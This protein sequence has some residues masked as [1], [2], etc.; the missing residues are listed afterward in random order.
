MET[1]VQEVHILKVKLEKMNVKQ[2]ELERKLKTIEDLAAQTKIKVGNIHIC[3]IMTISIIICKYPIWR[4]GISLLKH[5]WV[6]K[7]MHD[8]TDMYI[9]CI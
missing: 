8:I 9:H 1:L 6:Y 3:N 4:I 2:R 7:C 5:L